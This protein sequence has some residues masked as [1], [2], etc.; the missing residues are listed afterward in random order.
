MPT[1][2]SHVWRPSSARVV[3]LDSFVPVPRG[4]SPVAPAPLA[5]PAKD[6]TDV[7]DYLFDVSAAFAGNDGDGIASL[8]VAITPRQPGD[9]TLQSAV[10][11]GPVAVLWLT[12]GQ[13][14]T[15]YT[16]TIAIT[17]GSGRSVSR[18]VLLPVMY[19]AAPPNPDAALGIEGGA[20]LTDQSGNPVLAF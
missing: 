16:V 14:G 7:L 17:S 5:W 4:A 19:L 3:V 8:D 15:T 13:A 20:A 18:S 2:A 12:G 11:D 10:A 1:P 6:P 9:L